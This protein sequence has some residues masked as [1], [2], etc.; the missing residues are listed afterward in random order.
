[1][2]SKVYKIFI[3][4]IFLLFLSLQFSFAQQEPGA[5]PEL[6][7]FYS[8]SCEKCMKAKHELIPEIEKEFGNKVKV[9]YY[10]ISDIENYKIL[11]NLREKYNPSIEIEVPVFFLN[12]KFINAKADLSKRLRVFV[13]EALGFSPVDG[14][15]EQAVDL[16]R[17]FKSITPLVIVS[18]GLVD[19]INPCAFTVIVFFISFLA[20]QGYRRR[21][22]IVIGLTFIFSVFLTYVLIGLGLFGFLYRL[23]G[24]WIVTKTINLLIG[25]FSIGLGAAAL[26]DYFKFKKTGATE[27]LLLQ[28][29]AGIKNQIHKIIGLHYRRT[30]QNEQPAGNNILAVFSGALIT[31][32]LVS[33]LEAVCTGQTYVPTIAFVLKTTHLKLQ[34]LFYLLI[35]NIMFVVPLFIIF[36]FALLGVTSSQFSNFL[37]SRMLT[38]KILMSMLFFGLGIFLIWRL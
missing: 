2:N 16:I 34:A 9:K 26:Y 8:P 23:Q 19:G 15:K 37:K 5:L 11:L 24:F 36:I 27:G 38:I 22:L 31:G 13:V 21:D 14:I 25:I 12:G 17:H 10:D 18:A 3:V 28:L 20:L 29:P 35:Y 30:Q 7:V 33:L 4:G 32:F 6:S 1:M